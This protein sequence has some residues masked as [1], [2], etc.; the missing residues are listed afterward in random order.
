MSNIYLSLSKVFLAASLLQALP[1]SSQQA[2]TVTAGVCTVVSQDFNAGNGRFSS[3]SL[4]GNRDDEEFL[5]HTAR[6][7]WT[8]MDATAPVTPPAP[9]SVSI[10]SPYYVNPNPAGQFHVGFRYIVPN[11][12]TDSFKVRLFRISSG[13]AGEEPLTEQVAFSKYYAFSAFS[14]PT[15][16]TDPSNP[17]HNGFQGQACIR[18]NDGDITN[19]SNIRYRVEIAY[20]IGTT[21]FAAF[22]DFSVGSSEEGPLPVDFI[23]I[24]ATRNGSIA[25]IRWD[26]GDEIN[27][28]HYEVERS[29]TGRN[30]APIG[31]VPAAGKTVYGFTDEESPAGTIFYR[32]R[33]VDVDGRVKYS[34]IIRIAGD[35]SY[36]PRLQVYPVPAGNEL[37]IQHPSV[38][39]GARIRILTSDG[40]TLREVTPVPGASH[41]PVNI[42]FL[43]GGLYLLRLD[44][45]RGKSETVKFLKQ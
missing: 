34:S 42:T 45:G 18:L 22:D 8:E 26:V 20:K 17:A 16:Y 27:V 31:K 6:G 28:Q 29:T 7:T 10:I 1:G 21:G 19:G 2:T 36:A 24:A 4:Y 41:T 38:A 12:Q 37:T 13:P 35:N 43:K 39:D 14:T 15:A 11:A 40:R 32:I 23:G 30:F 9:R 33:S 25:D 3:P 44:D 5:F